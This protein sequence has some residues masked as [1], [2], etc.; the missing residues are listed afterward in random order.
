METALLNRMKGTP[1]ANPRYT[2]P[3]T[4][5]SQ[6]HWSLLGQPG[7]GH[8]K[9]DGKSNGHGLLYWLLALAFLIAL[10]A[11]ILVIIHICFYPFKH[12][13]K[14][15]H[16]DI[17]N[18]RQEL[19][20]HHRPCGFSARKKG[21]QFIPSNYAMTIRNWTRHGGWPAYDDSDGAMN[22][23]N[24]VFKANK[25]ARY[26]VEATGCWKNPISVGRRE[27][28]LMTSGNG[29]M[30]V[31]DRAQAETNLGLGI[32]DCLHL[33]QVMKIPEG[34]MVWIDAFTNTHTESGEAITTQ[35][36][37]SIERIAFAPKLRKRGH[38]G[39]GHGHGHGHGNDDDEEETK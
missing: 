24:G 7:R 14:Q 21:N 33:S 20:F 25:T 9:D 4:I 5:P 34:G 17:K 3:Q 16:R 35:S 38:G 10:V 23:R 32:Q 19:L 18:L 30:T 13:K 26:I 29:E 15:L 36:R 12:A 1:S 28:R 31:Y 22:F 2:T 8:G 37:F 39:W 6:V 27:I 11:L